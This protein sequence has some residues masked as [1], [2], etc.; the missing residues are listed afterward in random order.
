MLFFQNLSTKKTSQVKILTNTIVRPGLTAAQVTAYLRENFDFLEHHIMEEVELEQLERWMIRRTQRARKQTLTM[1]GACKNGGGSGGRKTSL[2]RWKFCVHAD[3]RQMLLSLT[4]SLQQRPT[5]AHV[6]FELANCIASAV[7]VDDFRLYLA[8]SGDPE[9]LRQYMGQDCVENG[10]PTMRRTA[11]V[12]VTV[13]RYVARTRETVRLS[14]GDV[15]ARFP[16]G[17]S[18][19]V[20]FCVQ[21]RHL[22]CLEHALPFR[23]SPVYILS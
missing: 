18:N 2:S 22:S 21:S 8:E 19:T 4:H 17:I 15:D 13:P 1:T 10:E 6:L 3:K 20:G 11:A 16:D 7:D 23:M 14:H 9:Q 12:G 5:R